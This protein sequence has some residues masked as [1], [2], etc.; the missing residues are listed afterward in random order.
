MM[1]SD[2]EIAARIWQPCRP[3]GWSLHVSPK[4]AISCMQP[5]SIDLTLHSKIKVEWGDENIWRPLVWTEVDIAGYDHFHGDDRHGQPQTGYPIMPGQVVLASTAERFVIP[6]DLSAR[7]EGK[8]SLGRLFVTTH[9]TAGFVDPG[10][11]GDITL[12]IVN[13]GPV[14]QYLQA[15]MKICQISFT[16]LTSPALRPYGSDGLG[17]HYQG[18]AGPTESAG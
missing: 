6:N 7:V 4:P 3:P 18:Q 5:A 1:L 16:Q 9:Q 8:S 15:G 17:S 2:R 13:V 11:V 14:V 12:E 10:F